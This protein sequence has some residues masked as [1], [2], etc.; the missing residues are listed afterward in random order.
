MGGAVL[1]E[2]SLSFRGIGIQ[3]PNA[4]WG[5]MLKEGRRYWQI[6]PHLMLIPAVTIGL[7]QVAANVSHRC[8]GSISDRA[9]TRR[10]K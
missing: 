1:L 9:V 8:S 10:Q 7:V 5:L 4:S 2:G 3:P 6:Y